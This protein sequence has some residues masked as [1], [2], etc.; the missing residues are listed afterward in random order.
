M[1]SNYTVTVKVDAGGAI[2][3]LDEI[4]TTVASSNSNL[5][6][7]R[8]ELK[9][10]QSELLALEPGT[11]EFDRL[12]KK[13]GD[14]KDR[15]NDVSEAVRANAG[16][17]LESIGNQSAQLRERFLNLDLKGVGESFAGIGGSIKKVSFKDLQD[18]IGGLGK[19]LATLGKA[20]LT[21][22]VFLIGAA[23]ALIVTNF[24]KLSALVDGV[25]DEQSKLL[26][27]QQDAAAASKEQLDNVSAQENILRMQGK[28]ERQILEIK[29]KAVQSAIESQKVAIETQKT[30]LKGQID[31]AKR[32]KEI[33]EGVFKF[34]TAPLQCILMLIDKIAGSDLQ[35]Q[36]NNFVA[37]SVFAPEQIEK[38]GLA[39]IEEQ[40]KAL[41]ALENQQAGFQNS[42]KQIDKSAADEKKKK[43][44]EE[45]KLE[46]D[47]QNKI[48]EIY[49]QAEE[50]R[51]NARED[52][53]SQIEQLEEDY[54]LSKLSDLDKELRQLQDFYFNLKETAKQNGIDITTIEEIEAAKRAEIAAKY[55]KKEGDI[56]VTTTEDTV[57][58]EQALGQEKLAIAQ[59]YVA[60]IGALNTALV[61]SGLVSAK[62]GFQIAKAIGV[63]EATISTI[64]GVNNALTAKTIFPEPF[65]TAFRAANAIAIASAGALNIAKIA[66]TQFNAGGSSG[67]PSVGSVGGSSSAG[68]G[69]ASTPSFNPLDTGFIQDRPPQVQA[70]VLAGSAANEA[71]RRQKIEDLSRLN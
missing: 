31:A 26:E 44:E 65:G 2:E 24:E 68:G 5:I 43:R 1:E 15:M 29:Q 16:P 33:L 35:N 22:P 17:A 41:K 48:T 63:A 58:I 47:K 11:K 34:I 4:K 40:E 23:V 7:L 51:K 45:I 36:L 66:R 19:G 32:N 37:T 20:L 25:S 12:A 9:S 70:Y 62:K 57:K 30:V 67:A 28:T 39:A 21:N 50:N 18:Q 56:V 3:N 46:Q 60:S 6:Q 27:N 55:A 14:L 49:R 10:V 42:I 69:A 54:E 38:D 13:A 59:N 61:D 52:V 53:L 71:E 8:K 64:N